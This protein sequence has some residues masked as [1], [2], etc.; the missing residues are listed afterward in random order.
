MNT[1]QYHFLRLLSGNNSLRGDILEHQK[2]LYQVGSATYVIER[3]FSERR[4]P[5]DVVVEEIITSAKQKIEI[6]GAAK[7][8]V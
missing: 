6:G 1:S 4:T 5:Q 7:K 8:M 3:V 2:T